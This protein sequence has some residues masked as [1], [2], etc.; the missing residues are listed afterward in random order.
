VKEFE[1]ARMVIPIS[2]VDGSIISSCPSSVQL[3]KV[4]K[5]ARRIGMNV[6]PLQSRLLGIPNPG[7]PV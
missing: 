1:L 5:E 7:H 4:H 3:Q 6:H 2:D